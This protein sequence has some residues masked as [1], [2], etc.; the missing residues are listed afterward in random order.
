VPQFFYEK[1][2]HFAASFYLKPGFL[3]I[4]SEIPVFFIL[5]GKGVGRQAGCVQTKNLIV[6]KL[7][8]IYG[9]LLTKT[10]G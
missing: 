2:R 10:Q 5:A 3:K 4:A 6:K 9:W 7:T 1:V 8:E